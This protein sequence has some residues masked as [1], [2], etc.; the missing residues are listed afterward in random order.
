FALGRMVEALSKSSFWAQTL[1]LVTEDDAQDGVDHVDGHRTVCFA[2]GP[3]V[4]RGALDSTHYAHASLVRTIQEIFRI[5]PRTRFLAAA[6]PMTSIFQPQAELTPY[7]VLQPRI[8]LTEM[9]RP[10]SSLSGREREAALASLRFNPH[11]VDDIPT[12]TMNRILWWDAKGYSVPYP[13]RLASTVPR[14]SGTSGKA[15]PAP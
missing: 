15:S 3:H 12:A 2:I 4:R 10:V 11:H 9:N 14:R 8:S 1:V 5:P 7:T 6:R 13:V